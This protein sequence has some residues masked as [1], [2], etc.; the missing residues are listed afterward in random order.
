[1]IF[2]KIHFQ[3]K[4]QGDE[5][6]LEKIPEEKENWCKDKGKKDNP[7]GNKSEKT[8]KIEDIDNDYFSNLTKNI[9]TN[10]SH[11]DK[12]YII[13]SPRKLNNNSK[14]NFYISTKTFLITLQEE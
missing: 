12:N 13:R 8:K 3:T 9:Y 7:H 11:F 10:E 2:I 5:I 1:M 4:S 6:F 14:S